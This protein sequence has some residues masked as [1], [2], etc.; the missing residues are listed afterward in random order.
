MKRLLLAIPL[1]AALAAARS[2][3][4]ATVACETCTSGR[5][6]HL[7]SYACGS[8]PDNPEVPL[9]CL[10]EVCENRTS[11]RPDICEERPSIDDEGFDGPIDRTVFQV[12]EGGTLDRGGFPPFDPPPLI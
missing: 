5:T 12:R 11:C 1:F 9:F 8:D 3:A 10:R 7:E 4:A 6:C 2:A